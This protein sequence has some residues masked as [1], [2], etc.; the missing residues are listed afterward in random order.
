MPHSAASNPVLCRLAPGPVHG[1]MMQIIENVVGMYFWMPLHG[2]LIW[3][4]MTG[5][6]LVVRLINFLS[7]LWLFFLSSLIVYSGK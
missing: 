4:W 6:E 7:L 3:N 5:E 2:V 1:C